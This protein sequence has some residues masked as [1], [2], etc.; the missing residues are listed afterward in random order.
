[1]NKTKL[2]L[3]LAVT[4]L[5]ICL[6]PPITLLVAGE[7]DNNIF[8]RADGSIDP[9]TA[10]IIRDGNTYILTE[11][12]Y[13][14][15]IIVEKDGVTIDGNGHVIQ[16][17]NIP[18]SKGVD[19]TARK[20]VTVKRLKIV[21]FYF[22]ISLNN[23]QYN[24]VL[25]N[26]ISSCTYIISAAGSENNKI[27][28]NNFLSPP[29]RVS[30]GA[31]LWDNGYPDGG[32]FWSGSYIEDYYSGPL[33]NTEG[34]DG[35]GDYIYE[36]DEDNFDSYP[37]MGSF[38]AF[39]LKKQETTYLIYI[40]SDSRISSVTYGLDGREISFY[41]DD[42]AGSNGFCL[43]C[44]SH[45]LLN[46]SYKV[47]VDGQ[48]PPYVNYNLYDNGT[49]RWIYFSYENPKEVEIIPEFPLMIILPF[50]L[51]ITIIV[52]IYRR[53]FPKGTLVVNGG[54]EK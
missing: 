3:I 12:I 34:Q 23:S 6:L 54:K 32:N 1:M 49:H 46:E 53:K 9:S 5:T 35:I 39:E 37:L 21:N 14:K 11:D 19:L 30:G 38:Y 22:G 7:A 29:N 10:P 28:H 48:D 52:M 40:I 16:G 26:T 44:I 25:E 31:N 18:L 13:N 17:V 41:A 33:Q 20:H 47:L 8:I 36:I 50:L 4:I 43:V 2:A 27:Y 15:S 51:T 42:G 45:A 24:I